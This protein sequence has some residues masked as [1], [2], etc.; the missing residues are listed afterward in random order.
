[1]L[2][3]SRIGAMTGFVAAISMTATPAAAADLPVAQPLGS[4]IFT[5][6]GH[7]AYDGELA[8][9]EWGRW[10]RRGWRRGGWRRH[11]GVRTGDVLAGVLILGGIAAVASAANKN[12]RDRDVVIVERDR[13]YDRDYDRRDRNTD[14]RS[15]AGSGLDNA[16]DQCVREIERDVRVDTVDGVDRTAQGWR[17]TGALF[18]GSG[19]TCQIDN[20]GRIAD[21]DYG[22]FRGSSYQPGDTVRARGD[23][24]QWSDARYAQARQAQADVSYTAPE[25]VATASD[26]PQ[27]A[28]PGGPLPGESFDEETDAEIGG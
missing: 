4:S 7:S 19:F 2:S 23:D 15:T 1:M 21:I 26:G 18:N 16:V 20:D 8:T 12:R 17:V 5:D 27:P 24:I 13:N 3:K 14:R 28:Y 10:G 6:F 25:T 22:S 11:R 9:A